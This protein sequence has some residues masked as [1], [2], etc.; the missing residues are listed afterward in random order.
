MSRGRGRVLRL[1]YW[2]AVVA[3]SLALAVAVLV[4]LQSLDASTVGVVA[5]GPG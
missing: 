2:L 1:L 3:L 4:L 5:T